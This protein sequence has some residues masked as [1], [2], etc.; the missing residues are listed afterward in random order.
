MHELRTAEVK[1]ARLAMVAMMGMWTQVVLTNSGPLANWA[2]FTEQLHVLF[3]EGLQAGWLPLPAAVR[4][5][6][7][8]AA[9]V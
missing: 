2:H 1:H 6:L 4:G 3:V 9:V 7:V 5:A 8:G